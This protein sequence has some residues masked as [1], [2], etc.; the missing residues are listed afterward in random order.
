MDITN[1]KLKCDYS[2]S[3]AIGLIIIW[4]LISLLT[5]G[6]GLFLMPYYVLKGPINRTKL[7]GKDGAPVGQLYVEV[8]LAEI[9]GHAIIWMLLS[10][11]TFGLAMF[12]YYPSVIKSL[13][14]KVEVR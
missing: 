4:I 8:N 13:L 12:V 10:I 1:Y 9:I 14:N 3:E 6:F 11:V 5:F 7:I 2:V